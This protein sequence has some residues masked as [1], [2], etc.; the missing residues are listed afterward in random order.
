MLRKRERK[1]K[2]IALTLMRD[3]QGSDARSHVIS[4][5]GAPPAIC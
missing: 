2:S 1:G 5:T 4:S 3:M